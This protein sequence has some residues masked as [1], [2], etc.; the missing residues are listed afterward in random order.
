MNVK[1]FL[2]TNFLLQV[3]FEPE[4]SAQVET[5]LQQYAMAATKVCEVNNKSKLGLIS[6]LASQQKEREGQFYL[7]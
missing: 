2:V 5:I 6:F 3:F 7:P 1:L 4:D